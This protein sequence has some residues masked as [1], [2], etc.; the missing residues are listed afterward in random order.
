MPVKMVKRSEAMAA[1]AF[2]IGIASIVCLFSPEITLGMAPLGVIIACL[3]REDDCKF[4][5]KAIIGIVLS[6]LAFIAAIYLIVSTIMALVNQAG[7]FDEFINLM[8]TQFQ[9]ILKGQVI[10]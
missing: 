10:F 1:T 9:N 6:I 2:G 8:Y 7:G 5:K 4:N 3:S